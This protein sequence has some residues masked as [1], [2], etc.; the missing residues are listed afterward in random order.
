M[1][2][3]AIS[4]LPGNSQVPLIACAGDDGCIQLFNLQTLEG[5]PGCVKT[6]S[7]PGHEDWIRALA[8]TVEGFLLLI[9]VFISDNYI[10][11][12]FLCYN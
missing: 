1:F 9:P 3:C 12:C 2:D 6:M 11:A 4:L 5:E 7:I 8:F 10:N